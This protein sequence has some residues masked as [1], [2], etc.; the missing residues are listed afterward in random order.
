MTDS[1]IGGGP[2]GVLAT[3]RSTTPSPP[4]SGGV[5]AAHRPGPQASAVQGVARLPTFVRRFPP[6]GPRGCGGGGRDRPRGVA[7]CRASATFDPVPMVAG[8][9]RA[10][11]L[12]HAAACSVG[13]V[14]PRGGDSARPGGV[15][16][17]SGLPP[18]AWLGCGPGRAVCGP[19]V[20]CFK[21][22]RK[23]A[24]FR[25]V[26]GLRWRAACRRCRSRA[27][28]DDA[29]RGAGFMDGGG[30]SDP[31]RRQNGI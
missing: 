16:L 29:R 10:S 15:S 13:R 11:P 31:L 12:G 14:I 25:S 4:R 18:R 9:C 21:V 2:G 30:W 28:A 23:P 26:P 6:F 5:R 20:L 3:L 27:G 19:G 17:W 7:L 1:T 24:V 22:K 8:R